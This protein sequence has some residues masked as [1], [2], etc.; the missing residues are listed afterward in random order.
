MRMQDKVMIGFLAI[1]LLSAPFIRMSLLK[2]E[3]SEPIA[4]EKKETLIVGTN[5][6]Y[7]P[8]TYIEDK[9]IKGFDIDV[10]NEI[11]SRLSKTTKFID[12][13]FDSIIPATLL[14]KVQVVAAG[15][16]KTPT[17]EKKVLFSKPYHEGDRLMIVVKKDS[18]IKEMKDLIGKRLIVNEGYTADLYVSSVNTDGI[19]IIRLNAPADGFMAINSNRAEAFVTSQ[20]TVQSFI[21]TTTTNTSA[22]K[23]N[24]INDEKAVDHY[25]IVVSPKHAH[26]LEKINTLLDQMTT[27]GTMTNLKI[28]WKLND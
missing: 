27:D 22:Y 4:L 18:V 7:P 3:A 8:F 2:K 28:K 25:Y 13:P 19:D 5:A 1:G 17:R 24:F 15:M 23:Y 9:Q 21:D 20:A 14:G 16:T 12:M 6:E 10:I 11:A 26:L